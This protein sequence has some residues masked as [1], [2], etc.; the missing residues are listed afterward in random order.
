MDL[1]RGEQCLIDEV[2]S[3]IETPAIAESVTQLI[4]VV[5][6]IMTANGEL[7]APGLVNVAPAEITEDDVTTYRHWGVKISRD[8]EATLIKSFPV[9]GDK[10]LKESKVYK[11]LLQKYQAEGRVM[12]E[13]QETALVRGLIRAGG[14]I[15]AAGPIVLDHLQTIS[16]VGEQACL[17]KL[18][19]GNASGVYSTSSALITY[20]FGYKYREGSDLASRKS[21]QFLV[22]LGLLY[23]RAFYSDP[24]HLKTILGDNSATIVKLFLACCKDRSSLIMKAM[25]Y[26]KAND[27]Y[28]TDQEEQARVMG[29]DQ[30][31]IWGS[32]RYGVGNAASYVTGEFDAGLAFYRMRISRISD[33]KR[34]IRDDKREEVIKVRLP[35]LY[36]DMTL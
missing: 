17:E 9:G 7:K 25:R 32:P 1:T 11:Y 30:S 34:F 24:S 8:K 22:N 4:T 3:D 19:A 5:D 13:E 31:A 28:I 12:S 16:T 14:F 35:L 15:A 21:N 26:L 20:V 36:D 27:S 29:W 2:H 6:S 33:T 10:W 18:V 23:R